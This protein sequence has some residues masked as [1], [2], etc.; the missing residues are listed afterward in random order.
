MFP[1]GTFAGTALALGQL[2]RAQP[3]KVLGAAI[4]CCQVAVWL[5]VSAMT[6][7][8]GL[9]G[10]LF[11]PPCLAP[12]PCNKD[13]PAA[14]TQLERQLSQVPGDGRSALGELHAEA[15][16]AVMQPHFAAAR[17]S[18][19]QLESASGGAPAGAAFA[20]A[21]DSFCSPHWPC[22]HS[23][24]WSEPPA[25][26]K[27]LAAADHHWRPHRSAS[28]HTVVVQPLYGIRVG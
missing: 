2:F 17:A 4:C 26:P 7:H 28:C 1:I 25:T 22:A 10:E 19:W 13:L 3:F 27:A 6:I 18:G 5:F 15:F 20:G 23:K 14:A 8:K 16:A 24:T 21:V 12:P 9:T 11:H